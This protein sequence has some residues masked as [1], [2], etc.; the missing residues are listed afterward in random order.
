M[1]ATWGAAADGFLDGL[2]GMKDRPARG[3]CPQ[4]SR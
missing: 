3:G 2:A 1:D 4:P